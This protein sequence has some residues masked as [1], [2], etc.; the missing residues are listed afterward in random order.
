VISL[1][2]GDR[3]DEIRVNE[4]DQEDGIRVNEGDRED[5]IRVNEG[6]R[7]DEIR[8]KRRRSRGCDI[9]RR[10]SEGGGGANWVE[11]KGRGSGGLGRRI[12]AFP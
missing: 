12:T 2:E 3:E 10:A 4:G 1:N 7:E 11:K 5:E 8:V 9:K 6:D